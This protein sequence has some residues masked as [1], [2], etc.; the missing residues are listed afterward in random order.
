MKATLTLPTKNLIVKGEAALTPQAELGLRKLI[1]IETKLKEIRM[2]FEEAL[3][4]EMEKKH[5]MHIEKGDLKIRRSLS[6]RKFDFDPTSKV[7]GKYLK[8]VSY[9]NP[10]SETI[11]A[12]LL[13]KGRLPKGIIE[14]PRKL[15]VEIKLIEGGEK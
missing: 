5:V 2:G 6:G 12:Y 4:T 3:L 13:L 9:N 1:E 15:G 10:N 8:P 11:E 14:K 7:D